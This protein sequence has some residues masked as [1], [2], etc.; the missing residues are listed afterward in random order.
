MN[1]WGN[2]RKQ[3]VFLMDIGIIVAVS[4]ILFLLS[5]LGN[6][7][8]DRNLIPLFLNLCVWVGCIAA[9]Q[10]LFHTYDSLWRYAEAREYMSL[11]L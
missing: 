10:A 9:F 3:I 4:V 2:Y 11:L 8:G 7:T 5:P 6:G 1:K